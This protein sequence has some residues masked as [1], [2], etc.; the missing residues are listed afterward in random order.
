MRSFQQCVSVCECARVLAL[1]NKNIFRHQN[2][3]VMRKSRSVTHSYKLPTRCKESFISFL[4]KQRQ[5]RFSSQGESNYITDC[6]PSPCTWV[7]AVG[8]TVYDPVV[9]GWSL[10]I[11]QPAGP[12]FTTSYHVRRSVLHD[13]H[14]S[15]N[16]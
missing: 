15:V 6:I 8:T 14:Y 4:M 9:P 3:V 5:E 1:L 10:N 16:N 2:A 7:R 11:P 13:F 12:H